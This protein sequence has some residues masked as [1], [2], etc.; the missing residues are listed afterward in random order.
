MGDKIGSGFC[1]MNSSFTPL[2][3]YWQLSIFYTL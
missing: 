1:Y 3:H 2:N